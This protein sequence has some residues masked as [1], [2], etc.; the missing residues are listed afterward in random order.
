MRCMSQSALMQ[1]SALADLGTAVRAK[2]EAQGLS[3][4]ALAT[5]AGV[6]TRT[7]INVEQGKDARFG[8][9]VQ[10]A[11]A[12]DTTVASLLAHVEPAEVAS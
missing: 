12:L 5:R 11:A 6:A 10:L 7:L 3:Q 9:L 4:Q 2:R 1:N 8:T